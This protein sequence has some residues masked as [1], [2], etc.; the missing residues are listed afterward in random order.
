MGFKCGKL[1][2]KKYLDSPPDIKEDT[3]QQEF[4]V[5]CL[6]RR[7]VTGDGEHKSGV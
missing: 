2:L 6:R 7:L 1:E 4:K 5:V 3:W